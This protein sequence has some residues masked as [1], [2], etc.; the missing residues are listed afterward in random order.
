MPKKYDFRNTKLSKFLD[1]L[2][3]DAPT[4]GGGAGAALSGATGAALGE[5][6]ARINAKRAKKK[7]KTLRR[8]W[9]SPKSFRRS[10]PFLSTSWAATQKRSRG[11]RYR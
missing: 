10:A 11:S 5:M 7:T 9:P 2:A 3:S 6:T 8:P 1:A 4:P